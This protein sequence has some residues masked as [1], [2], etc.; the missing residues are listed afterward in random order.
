MILGIGSDITNIDRIANVLKRHGARFSARVFTKTEQEK[1]KS[2]K[3][4]A[5]SYALR[6][7]AKEACSKALGTGIGTRLS[8]QDIGVENLASGQPVL[9]LS[10]GAENRLLEITPKAHDAFLHLSLSDDPPWAQ[11]FVIIE[12]L[13]SKDLREA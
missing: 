6:W 10:G 2:K 8:W 9:K 11:A 7:A 4:S 3:D 12:A 1:A 13:P 5:A